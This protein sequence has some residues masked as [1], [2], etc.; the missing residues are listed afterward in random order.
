MTIASLMIK[1]TKYP[2]CVSIKHPFGVLDR[3][4]ERQIAMKN[5]KLTIHPKLEYIKAICGLNVFEKR[6]I[7]S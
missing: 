1:L 3:N 5:S 4:V 7:S 6:H 2:K